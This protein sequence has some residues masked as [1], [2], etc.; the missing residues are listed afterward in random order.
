MLICMLTMQFAVAAYVC[1]GMAMADSSGDQSMIHCD[2]MD[3][4]QPGLCHIQAHDQTHKQSLDKPDIPDVAPFVPN[5]L[6]LTTAID[7]DA[8][9]SIGLPPTPLSLTRTTAPPI[10][11]RHCCFRI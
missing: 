5:G 6:V 7:G 9:D 11:I 10:A 1:P 4:A 3:M 2:G 8:I